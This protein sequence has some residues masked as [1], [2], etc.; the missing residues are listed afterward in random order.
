MF[1]RIGLPELLII[2]FA[3][4]APPLLLWRPTWLR[5]IVA[6]VLEY[7]DYASARR[8]L[9]QSVANS[10]R[11]IGYAVAGDLGNVVVWASLVALDVPLE[12]A[13]LLASWMGRGLILVAVAVDLRPGHRRDTKYAYLLVGTALSSFPGLNTALVVASWFA[14]RAW[15]AKALAQS[16]RRQFVRL[17]T[18]SRWAGKLAPFAFF[19]L[20]PIVPPLLVFRFLVLEAA[21]I[22]PII[23]LRSFQQADV[24]SL[25][26]RVVLQTA[27][28]V[29]YVLS[30]VHDR[31]R[32]AGLMR[33]GSLADH[34]GTVVVPDEEWE[35][36]LAERL[37][38][39]HA[40]IIDVSVPTRGVL[41][42]VSQSMRLLPERLLIVCAEDK[43]ADGQARPPIRI[44]YGRS[45]ASLRAARQQMMAWL[46]ALPARS[47]IGAPPIGGIANRELDVGTRTPRRSTEQRVVG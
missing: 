17:V 42:E 38:K 9:P 29:G 31:Q 37:S 21:A 27:G 40:A 33:W 41:W 6:R 19:L 28:R 46:D 1:G 45:R 4:V 26:G 34:A 25:F 32:Q 14:S 24:A 43:T 11:I 15:I 3:L 12:M 18:R 44:V 5:L 35:A 20:P 16:D 10:P 23:F 2:L 30:I 36:W 47:T 13:A 7:R 8:R 22:S 39:A